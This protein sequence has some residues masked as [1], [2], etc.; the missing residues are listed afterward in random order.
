MNEFNPTTQN[1]VDLERSILSLKDKK[2]CFVSQKIEYQE[3]AGIL[4]D[5]VNGLHNTEE[6][7]DVA[8][9]ARTVNKRTLTSLETDIK[10]VNAE[11]NKKHQLLLSV[12]H[13]LSIKKKLEKGELKLLDAIT[14]LKKEYLVFASDRSR[15]S[16]M[17]AMASEV[18]LKLENIIKANT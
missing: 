10:E 1:K 13:H 3:T 18:A 11:I 4:K 12:N 14:S 5:K 17:R 16:S 9:A 2:A 7:Y 6:G 15:I 8:V